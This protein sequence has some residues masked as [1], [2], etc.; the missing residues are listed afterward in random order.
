MNH[1]LDIVK[2]PIKDLWGTR[3]FWPRIKDFKIVNRKGI[4]KCEIVREQ[5]EFRIPNLNLV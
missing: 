4:Q 5:L 2:G 1:K 3:N